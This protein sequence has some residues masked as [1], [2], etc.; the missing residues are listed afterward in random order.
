LD[1]IVV[2]VVVVVVVV[3]VVVV[4]VVVVVIVVA[5]V[6]YGQLIQLSFDR[7]IHRDKCATCVLRSCPISFILFFLLG[8]TRYPFLL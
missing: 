7:D 6:V 5:V 3:T 4:V 2:V 1:E 8:F